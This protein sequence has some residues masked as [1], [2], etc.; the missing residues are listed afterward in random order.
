MSVKD[1]FN[2]RKNNKVITKSKQEEIEKNVESSALISEKVKERKS[3]VSHIDYSKPENF[4]RYG[5]AERYYQDSFRR[6]YQTYPYDG[7][8]LEKTKWHNESSGL[9]KWIFDNVY[10]KTVGH[11]KLGTGQ[12]IYVK[13]GPNRDPSVA[14]NDKEELSKQYPHKE[15][16]ANIWDPEIYRTANVHINGTLGNTVEFWAKLEGSVSGDVYPFVAGNE[17]GNRI[18]VAYNT[19]SSV[20]SL[21]YTDDTSTGLS[22]AD[23]Q[24]TISN[25]LG[26][27][28][29]HYALSFINFG[30]DVQVEIYKNGTRIG[31]IKAGTN[32]DSISQAETYLNING[33][34]SGTNTVNGLYVDEFRFW[35]QRRTEEQIG[36]YWFTNVDGGTNTDNEKYSKENNK[37]DLGVYL[38]F[39]E[40]IVGN[41]SIDSIVLDYSG[42]I[43]NGTI[44]SYSLEVRKL[45]SA[46]DEYGLFDD[47]ETKDPIIY[48][49]HPSLAS[50][51][52]S[53]ETL[54][55]AHDYINNSSIF[56]TLPA[57]IIDEDEKT[58]NN[59]Q[60]FT[61]VLSSYFDETHQQIKEITDIGEV[62]YYSLKEENDKP[63][64]LIRDSLQSRGI[65][66]PDLFS[67]ANAIEEI[68]SR[69]EQDLFN[70]K[71]HDIKNTIYQNIYNNISFIFK[72]K[73]TEKS[74]RNLIRCFGIDDELVKINLYADN[75][76][77]TL[78]D[79]RRTT[80][81]KKNFVDFNSLTR[82]SATVY[83]QNDAARTETSSYIDAPS[84][85]NSNLISF[86][87]ET[88]FI[89]PKKADNG[90]P[91]FTTPIQSEEQILV[92]AEADPTQTGDSV[93]Q[94]SNP[95]IV[96]IYIE[97]EQDYSD[98]VKF[99][100]SLNFGGVNYLLKSDVYKSV[101]DNSKWNL[102][103]KLSPVKEFGDKIHGGATTDYE[104]EFY[105]V[106]TLSDSVE[107]EFTKTQIITSTAART[108]V[109]KKKFI[110]IG[111]SKQNYDPSEPNVN[112]KTNLKISST[113]FWYDYLSNEEIKAH[114]SDGSNFGRLHPNDDAYSFVANLSSGGTADIRV[115]RKDTLAMHWDFNGVATSDASGN[116]TV[117]DLSEGF[118]ASDSRYGW[119]TELVRKQVTGRGRHFQA[120][121]DQVT[122]REFIYSA[123]H[124]PPEVINSEELVEI[125]TQDDDK[126]TRDSRPITHFFAAEKSMYQ[127]INDQIVNLFATI[128]E[129]NDLIGQPINRYRMDYKSLEK[130]RQMFFERVKNVPSLEKYVDYYKWIDNSIGMMLEQLIPVSS[131]FS[132]ELR[133]MI[134]SH[135]LERNKYWTKFPTLEMEDQPIEANVRGINEMLY[136]YDLGRAPL[137]GED[138]CLWEKDRAERTGTTV[139]SGDA[140][141]DADR[142]K[143]RSVET[144]E[145]KGQTKLVDRGLGLVEESDPTLYDSSST[146]FYEGRVY[147]TRRLS[148]PYRLN[149]TKSPTIHGGVNYSETTK[150]PND[151]VRSSTPMGKSVEITSLD[152]NPRECSRESQIN[153]EFFKKFKR[154][155]TITLKDGSKTESLD[156]SFIYPRFG[157]SIDT[158]TADLKNLHNDS[159]GDDAE[160]P[161]Q[162]PFTS[163]WVGGNQHRHVVLSTYYG[164]DPNR[165]EL[166]LKS[167]NELK[168]P[169]DIDVNN[170][171]ARFLREEVA[172]RPLNIKNIK[173]VIIHDRVN[174]NEKPLG[175]YTH[176]YDVIQTSGRSKNNRWFV[177]DEGNQ[178]ANKRASTV[179]TGLSD[180]TLPDRTRAN[181][182]DFGRTENI[183]VERFSAP[184]DPLTMGLGFMDHEAAEFS[185]YN[186]MNFR[187][188]NVRSHLH[189]WL[190]QH[191]G[192]YEG[193]QGYRQDLAL[194]GI[195]AY[196]K[197]NRNRL[198]DVRL[199]NSGPSGESYV[200]KS[201]FDNAYVGH[202]IPRSDLQYHFVTS[203]V[204]PSQY[205]TS[206]NDV[207]GSKVPLRFSDYYNDFVISEGYDATSD[208][209]SYADY[210]GSGWRFIRGSERNE[211]VEGRK[212]NV[213][214]VI[215][216]DEQSSSNYREPIAA[217]N[218]PMTHRILRNSRDLQ[219]AIDFDME[220]S[221]PPTILARHA[222]SN[223]LEFFANPNLAARVE[224][225]KNSNQF[226]DEI[227]NLLSG[228][229]PL[230]QTPY[231]TSFFYKEIIYP[232]H[233]NV[234]LNK[235][236]ERS[237]FDGY[238]EF[239]DSLLLDR[240]TPA[241]QKSKLGFEKLVLA[242]KANGRLHES[243]FVMDYY[244]YQQN[245]GL[246]TRG[247][248][249]IGELNYG[250]INF[251]QSKILNK[252]RNAVSAEASVD[253]RDWGQEKLFDSSSSIAPF[254]NSSVIR[255]ERLRTQ[256][257]AQ[258]FYLPREHTDGQEKQW[259]PRK[260]ID[261]SQLVP[262]YDDYDHYGE[263]L[264]SIGQNYGILSEFRVSQHMDKYLLDGTVNYRQ[265]NYSFLSLDGASYDS[266]RHEGKTH[267]Q[268]SSKKDITKV[269]TYAI[270]LFPGQTADDIESTRKIVYPTSAQEALESYFIRNNNRPDGVV[271]G[272]D[273]SIN[274]LYAGGTFTIDNSV[275]TDV[276]ID[277][278]FPFVSPDRVPHQKGIN[279]A[280]QFNIE[281]ENDY[282]VAS[283]N[284]V[285]FR[286]PST[287]ASQSNRIFPA[288][289]GV[290]F[291]LSVWAQP[292]PER[293]TSGLFSCLGLQLSSSATA[294]MSVLE[295]VKFEGVK[296]K[297]T[298]SLGN[299]GLTVV[300]SDTPR[301]P[302][303]VDSYGSHDFRGTDVITFFRGDGK[304]AFL[305]EGQFNH[306]VFQL[307]SNKDV[308]NNTP[309]QTTLIKLWLN[310]EELYGA[311]PYALA[312]G[313]T[314][315][316]NAYSPASVGKPHSTVQPHGTDNLG[317]EYV[318]FA[319]SSF[320]K[321]LVLGNSNPVVALETNQSEETKR[322]R[323][324]GLLDELSVWSG[325]MT[326][327]SIGVLY[328]N[329][330]PSNLLN[331]IETD[332]FLPPSNLDDWKLSSTIPERF[333]KLDIDDTGIA[334][335]DPNATFGWSV[336]EM[337]RGTGSGSLVNEHLQMWHR[338]GVAYHE[339]ITECESWDD[340]FFN[341][342]VHSDNIKF[343]EKVTR[344]QESLGVKVEERVRLKVNAIKK[345]L[346]YDGFYPQDR[347]V[348]I[349]KLFTEKA[350]KSIKPQPEEAVFHNEQA[351]Q[352]ALQ[353]FFAPGILYNSI[354]AGIACDWA[355]FTDTYGLEQSAVS[356]SY[357]TSENVERTFKT[358]APHWYCPRQSRENLDEA[359]FELTESMDSGPLY[360][361][362][363]AHQP[364]VLGNLNMPS[365]SMY[366]FVTVTEPTTR[367]PF[368]ALINPTKFLSMAEPAESKT[369]F[370]N[371]SL[372]LNGWDC[373]GT[374][375]TFET[376]ESDPSG[377]GYYLKKN[378]ISIGTTQRPGFEDTDWDVDVREFMLA[379][380]NFTIDS[381][382]LDGSQGNT[383]LANQISDGEI[384]IDYLNEL[385][386]IRLCK[387]INEREDFSVIAIPGWTPTHQY[388]NPVRFEPLEPISYWFPTL[389]PELFGVRYSPTRISTPEGGL[390]STL[391][392]LEWGC[393]DQIIGKQN[394]GTW[395]IRLIA[396]GPIE[397]TIETFG[398]DGMPKQFL[399]V[400]HIASNASLTWKQFHCVR[401]TEAGE[402][403]P[404]NT[405]IQ[406]RLDH[407]SG[408]HSGFGRFEG[409]TGSV[410]TLLA[411][412]RVISGIAGGEFQVSGDRVTILG[413]Q[414]YSSP[415]SLGVKPFFT[416]D[417]YPNP[418]NVT[419]VNTRF[420]ISDRD[421]QGTGSTQQSLFVS[422][423]AS[424]PISGQLIF[425]DPHRYETEA[426][427][428]YCNKFF[429]MTPEYY[430]IRHQK[431]D[432]D[433][434]SRLRN[435]RD[436]VYPNFEWLSDSRSDIRYDNAIN[437][438]V[439]EV[440]KFF[441]QNSKLTTLTSRPEI[442]FKQMTAGVTYYMDVAI[443]KSKGF[444]IATTSGGEIPT[445][446]FGPAMKWKELRDYDV[447]TIEGIEDLTAPPSQAAYAPPYLYGKGVTRLAF[448][449]EESRVY[450]LNEILSKIT[451]EDVSREHNDY[452]RS[453]S[454]IVETII[455]PLTPDDEPE[456]GFRDFPG[457]ELPVMVREGVRVS[458]Y[459]NQ[460]AWKSR[461]KVESCLELLGKRRTRQVSFDLSSTKLEE[462]GVEKKKPMS[463]QD[464]AD[465]SYNS[466]C[467]ST[468]F[469]CP[470]LN[471]AHVRDL[472]GTD[473]AVQE[474]K[475]EEFTYSSFYRE[476]GVTAHKSG[477]GIWSSYGEIPRDGEGIF[478]SLEESFTSV[479]E[480]ERIGSLIDVCGFKSFKEQVGRIAQ[481]RTISEAVVM[482]PFVDSPLE[483][484]IRVDDRNFFSITPEKFIKQV[485]NVENG[486]P[487]VSAQDYGLE[488]DI[489]ETTITR[490]SKMMK[491]YNLPPRY[492]FMKFRSDS[493]PFVIY[494]FEFE[495][496]LD[497]EDLSNIWQGLQ[498]KIALTSRKDSNEVIHDL[499]PWE[500]FEGRKITQDVRWMVFKVKKTACMDYETLLNDSIQDQRFDFETTAGVEEP[501]YSYNYPYDYFS[502]VEMVKI[503]AGAEFEINPMELYKKKLPEEA[504]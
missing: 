88:E 52:S 194:P 317:I 158:A 479:S 70:E 113:L 128:V 127:I 465:T 104:L 351:I 251:Y 186:S 110:S 433:P 185:P 76:D 55:R 134:E 468:K 328:N 451:T 491:K 283:F 378:K 423:A 343:I 455:T 23:G 471:F 170:A 7:S 392:E 266:N 164:A 262:A 263:E 211:P 485:S 327:D 20:L 249:V 141:V 299:S 177:K 130:F 481:E 109:E 147:A 230:E 331:D 181:N 432:Q 501:Q 179:I 267:T 91:A 198:Y 463:A 383:I 225:V 213:I 175:N 367:L 447:T 54:G 434:S 436:Y 34:A 382:P 387:A 435:L 218:K 156:G 390:L 309:N 131:N 168:H 396:T 364:G 142:E 72:S 28:W 420:V 368:E 496:T 240:M 125:R 315:V 325:F 334:I 187:N 184:G 50:T 207:C 425:S 173:T 73:G 356:S 77:Y 195:A 264:R 341:S 183:F 428:S 227:N 493:K 320:N 391:S 384:T 504:E 126:F 313:A 94:N 16:N 171:S 350:K 32:V 58:G 189:Y 271:R 421:D 155:S 297:F 116:F 349:A 53:Y 30:N 132:S 402:I 361:L 456:D 121:D 474:R 337:S 82:D 289:F 233:R 301:L 205:E 102:A 444:E 224:V 1:L 439:A 466:W 478:I 407:F 80:A 118:A 19:T 366:G 261:Q 418:D 461:M 84:N 2:K 61:Q 140:N 243:S 323:F 453:R 319:A 371:L 446:Y 483:E 329:G 397:E 358:P 284:K 373:E 40:G 475:I 149:V 154:S 352:A 38:K 223:G 112:R 107:H 344:D 460:P 216:G 157:E 443:S 190:A 502:L 66:V 44:S 308:F 332:K 295:K 86:T 197:N 448:R 414:N 133:T 222:Y 43:S 417:G 35:K 294:S 123:K 256:P 476:Q 178:V 408:R 193:S 8:L 165:P 63:Y 217:W 46:L 162:G 98:N 47:L 374:I 6:I 136:N 199:V 25:F 239:W 365:H 362:L 385:I 278:P 314:H 355:S 248:E 457:F 310:G 503:E 229:F 9:D 95:P 146:T 333:R 51:L 253:V 252:I 139:T 39:N 469:E 300:F 96:D 304:P 74:F 268:F 97:K 166:F 172:K 236:R 201:T 386:A 400:N 470:V 234:G 459:R 226:Y 272:Q 473:V 488:S 145:I 4:A 399:K 62:K 18:Q 79:T 29:A 221:T 214:S 206:I 322:F 85:A 246:T 454:Q 71:I 357:T 159:Y 209:E 429:L 360:S 415:N 67:E 464:A 220:E 65:I 143:I 235:V 49:T 45:T 57:W 260:I 412:R 137:A 250:G 259:F 60:K 255:N 114:A 105:G 336:A 311:H 438:F 276:I 497:Q 219:I 292:N 15:G 117:E 87:V 424:D 5:S 108:E 381:V 228:N 290:P 68:L 176:D 359:L 122:N 499:A 144:R 279:A 78:E 498:P 291:N 21:T 348:Q 452:F 340:E 100:A 363:N 12:S 90:H 377:D 449:A 10:P 188:F 101:Y 410:A 3:F 27:S 161:M 339:E 282:L 458:D 24:V 33:T 394:N 307:V 480:G 212:E 405:N 196:Q 215:D 401:E 258:L 450:T 265:K 398:D 495:E 231:Y 370:K 484:T 489:E 92:V 59:L 393:T 342:Y 500:F 472:K 303:I 42:R 376:V 257:R 13:G 93:Y 430:E 298:D 83:C 286:D 369:K 270:N 306:I 437:N 372:E 338:L 413:S 324:S 269:R 151:F 129:F 203:S 375:L 163:Q 210:Q 380:K 296:N 404:H 153:T 492:D 482:I 11:V 75:S 416:S 275:N 442:E 14:V 395:V 56:N 237:K 406:E 81:I 293:E 462:D 254:Y 22:G 41:E 64:A 287:G 353:H 169:K 321:S 411:S 124:R 280:A 89:I 160:I 445:K 285:A 245:D 419:D 427:E 103:V 202:Q 335:T 135:V 69:G 26:T 204:D 345:L 192:L 494:F 232:K 119:F 302:E 182:Y 273:Q 244:Q 242:S 150:D 17:S 277:E 326:K 99:V 288:G 174:A 148:K 238:E 477:Q 422:T 274:P 467:I 241:W 138:K 152:I 379:P 247:Y 180:Y 440:P 208:Q 388:E 37:V 31:L 167:G 200:C 347:T 354:K 426:D 191:S 330:K 487:A 346:P 389:N 318:G 305:K 312:V 115:P 48:S 490:M 36:R 403:L 431:G 111:A 409:S 281:N 316:A 441:L 120:N 486:L 106:S